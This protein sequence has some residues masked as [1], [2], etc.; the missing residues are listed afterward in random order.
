MTMMQAFYLSDFTTAK[1]CIIPCNTA[2][3][4]AKVVNKWLIFG[5]WKKTESESK[6]KKDNTKLFLQDTGYHA[7][8]LGKA[9]GL[10]NMLSSD[11][12]TGHFSTGTYFAG[13]EDKISDGNYGERAKET[14]E[15]HQPAKKQQVMSFRLPASG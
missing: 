8:D 2:Y 5:A 6:S 10:W 14:G 13:N 15:T 7:G 12:S 9:E 4:S 3:F 11:R 1:Y